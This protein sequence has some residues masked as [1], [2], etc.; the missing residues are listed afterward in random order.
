M[1]LVPCVGPR[2]LG[3]HIWYRK[4]GAYHIKVFGVRSLYASKQVGEIAL[5]GLWVTVL[6]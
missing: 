5:G 1:V 4:K 3:M 2:V 6:F